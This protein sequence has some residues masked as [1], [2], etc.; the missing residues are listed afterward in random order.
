MSCCLVKKN[1]HAMFDTNLRPSRVATYERA[2]TA[3]RK[4]QI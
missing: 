2:L 1:L 4:Q 3:N